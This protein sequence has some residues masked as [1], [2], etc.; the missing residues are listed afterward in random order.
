[1]EQLSVFDK[2][3]E[4]PACFLRLLNVIVCIVAVGRLIDMIENSFSYFNASNHSLNTSKI[5][6]IYKKNQENSV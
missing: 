6:K 2:F 1:M 4:F 5:I 3:K